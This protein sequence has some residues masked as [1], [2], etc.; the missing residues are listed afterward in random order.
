MNLQLDFIIEAVS[1]RLLSGTC[2]GITQVSTDSRKIAPGT[3]FVALKGERFDGHDFLVNAIEVGASA[4]LVS[5]RDVD[6][7]SECKAAVILVDDT[8][9][10]LQKLAACYRQLFSLPVVAITGSVGKTTT[11]DILADCLTSRYNT[12]KTQGNFNNEIGLPMTLFNL[13]PEH[14]AA[15]LEMGMRAPGEIRHL[16]SLLHPDYAIITNVEPVHLETMGTLENIALAKCEVL[17]FI[18]DGFALL[19]GDNQ[20]LLNAASRFACKKYLFG[21]MD[22]NDIQIKSLVNDGKGIQVRLKIFACEEDYY[23][24]LPVSQLAYNLAAAAGMAFLLGVRS[25]EIRAS[26]KDFQPGGNRLNMTNLAGGGVLIDD[27]YNANPVS[28]MAALEACQKMSRGRRKVAIL[29][30]MLEL[31]SYEKE[32]HLKAGRKA[33]EVEIDILVTIGP[34]A[35]YY[36]EGALAQGMRESCI[37]HFESREEALVWLKANVST[38]NVI[39]VKASRGMHLD[40]LAQEL[41]S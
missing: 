27:S 11:K 26:L 30:D 4:V 40:K 35:Q 25:D 28:V 29:G 20:Y 10:A 7:P 24:P 8:L 38:D 34:L 9:V 12:L 18:K 15:V 2:A 21:F 39:L 32:G 19:N 3:L 33:A 23:L 16:A 31:G 13:Q 36:R 17:E 37:H 5:R 22:G 6:L 14:Q 1:G 41:F